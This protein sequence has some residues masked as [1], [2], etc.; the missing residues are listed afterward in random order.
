M[1]IKINMLE[2]SLERGENLVEALLKPTWCALNSLKNELR[3]GAVFHADFGKNSAKGPSIWFKSVHLS[4]GV[5]AEFQVFLAVE[6][7][8][9]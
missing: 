3:K 1:S 9:C 7:P 8:M 2:S 4:G 6:S 5:M